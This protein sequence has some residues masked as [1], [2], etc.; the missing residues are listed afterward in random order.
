MTSRVSFVAWSLP[1]R[2]ACHEFHHFQADGDCFTDTTEVVL[3]AVRAVEL[4]GDTASPTA[5]I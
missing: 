2:Q 5:V 3:G 1:L 4:A